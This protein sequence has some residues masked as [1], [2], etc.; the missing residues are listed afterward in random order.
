MTSGCS[1][2]VSVGVCTSSPPLYCVLP[3]P[4]VV[5]VDAGRRADRSRTVSARPCSVSGAART[6]SALAREDS[7]MTLRNWPHAQRPQTAEPLQS[8]RRTPLQAIACLPRELC[9]YVTPGSCIPMVVP[10]TFQPARTL[11]YARPGSGDS[12]LVNMRRV[13]DRNDEGGFRKVMRPT[14]RTDHAHGRRGGTLT[15]LR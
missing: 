6:S 11:G 3:M 5:S 2:I 13:D 9:R 10:A 7:A 8:V 1:H 15:A 4:C 12:D 14:L